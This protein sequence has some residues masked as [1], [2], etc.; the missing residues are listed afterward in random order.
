MR[1]LLAIVFPPLAVLSCG[2]PVQA[3]LNVVL[4]VF[5]WLPGV[6]H[7]FVVVSSGEADRRTDRLLVGMGG[8]LGPKPGRL[9]PVTLVLAAGMVGL[10]L[11]GAWGVL[12]M[13]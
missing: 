4:C 9:G 11:W 2:K 12:H 7:A 6:L 13:R 10:F 8:D 1:Y 5:F 3:M